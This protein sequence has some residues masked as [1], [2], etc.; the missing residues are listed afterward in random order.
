MFS[1]KNTIQIIIFLILL[2]ATS[3]IKNQTRITEK[4]LFKLNEKITITILPPGF[5]ILAA[6]IIPL[7]S[8]VISLLTKIL[9]A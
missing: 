5:K 1:S 7:I 3:I 8:S 6:L 2:I 9:I 4:K